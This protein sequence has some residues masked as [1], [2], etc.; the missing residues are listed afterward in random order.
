MQSVIYIGNNPP[1][2]RVLASYLQAQNTR[3]EALFLPFKEELTKLKEAK[4]I[5]LSSPIYVDGVYVSAEGLWKNYLEYHCP[6]AILLIA[7]FTEVSHSNYLDLLQLPDKFADFLPK[8][9]LANEKWG[10]VKSDGLDMMEKIHRFFEGHGDESLTDAFDKILRTL[11]IAGDELKVHHA[12]YEEVKKELLL[13]NNLPA[14][15]IVLKSR[16]ANYFPYFQC[17]PFFDYFKQI[18]TCLLEIDPFFETGCEQETL[19]WQLGCLE[20]IE[21]IKSNLTSISKH[22]VS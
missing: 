4:I 15:W 7:S 12:T 9:K 8:A 16:W 13:P 19:F 17:L 18:E 11:R 14:K 6:K 10:P 1:V 5:I 20:K 21:K 2:Q 22:Y 3:M